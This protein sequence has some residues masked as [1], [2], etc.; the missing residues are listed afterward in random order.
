MLNWT[1]KFNFVKRDKFD[2]LANIETFRISSV[3]KIK[4]KGL[5]KTFLTAKIHL[6]SA[7]MNLFLPLKINASTWQR[8]K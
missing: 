1:C 7:K 4:S 3:M 2:L 8:K 6:Q 5:R